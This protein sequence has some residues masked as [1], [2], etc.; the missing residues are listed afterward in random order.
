M[1]G[2]RY[3]TG[4]TLTELLI[5][6]AIIGILASVAVPAYTDFVSR[7]NRSEAQRE[8]LRVANLQEQYFVDHRA[9]TDVMTKLGLDADPFVTENKHYEI[10]ATLADG[11]FLLTAKARGTQKIND[12]GCLELSVTDTG[13]KAPS[14]TC[15]E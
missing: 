9:Y 14:G 15:W 4:F 5:T 2:R 6:V 7:S 8:L 13:K 3:I 10:D 11:G 1:K 12:T